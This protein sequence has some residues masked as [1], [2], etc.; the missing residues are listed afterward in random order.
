MSS[1]TSL[2]G[3]ATRARSFTVILA[4]T[5]AAACGDDAADDHGGDDHHHDAAPTGLAHTLFVAHEGA[6][7]SYDLATGLERPGT[8]TNVS[9]PVDLQAL[10]DGHL[11]VNLG[12]RNEILIVDPTSMLEV[13]RLPSSA[14]GGLRPTHGFLSPV[15][16]GRQ[17][18]MT[19]NDGDG[20]P[21]SNSARFIDVT[22]GSATRFQAVG[23]VG[24]GIG[25]HNAAFSRTRPRVVISNIGDCDD[26]LTVVDFTDPAQPT[27]V[28][29][30]TAVEAGWDGVTR[31]CEGA[32][33]PSPHGCAT[34]PASG[35]AYCSLT[36]TGE[37]AI[38]DL[39]ADVPTFATIATG[40]K[41]G[42]YTQ[43]HPAG[44]Y[45]YTMQSQP[46]DGATGATCQIG[47]LVITDT[48]TDTVA[49]E[50]PVRYTGPDCAT[51]LA[52]DETAVAPDHTY[53]SH[54]GATLF[55]ALNAGFGNPAARSRQLVVIDTRDPAA[56]AQLPS[57]AVG[58]STSHGAGAVDG[59]G[60]RAFVVNAIDGTISEIDATTR[61][62]VRT[63][64]VGDNPRAVA[65][66]GS[67]EG[68]S[69]QT[70]P[71]D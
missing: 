29:T 12:G 32:G 15:L 9:G 5:T 51:A 43:L 2:R 46:R 13:A 10:D 60:A 71:V 35:K 30:L 53:W 45:A 48:T 57:I 52:G 41:G 6:L 1:R 67:A 39:D 65:T 40:G 33:R 11:I 50:L 25:H 66:Y 59:P 61:A 27:P 62:V 16:G 28:E 56:P 70:G 4:M 3:R 49:T 68:P 14:A 17:L 34:S 44:R 54:D 19:L 63:L 42:G 37:L 20:T 58:V 24:L 22:A 55:I 23:E 47:Q 64:D 8:V 21:A 38:I 7:V 69:H 36:A 31:I 18:W 26:L